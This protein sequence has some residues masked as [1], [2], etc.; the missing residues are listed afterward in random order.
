M[1]PAGLGG[2][3]PAHPV[4]LAHPAHGLL[5]SHPPGGVVVEVDQGH[6][7]GPGLLAVQELTRHQG[8]ELVVVG[9]PAPRKL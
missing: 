3:R 7:V 9:T 8:A 2:A 1:P 6:G 4:A 5:D